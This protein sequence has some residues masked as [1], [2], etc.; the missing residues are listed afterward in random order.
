MREL[1]NE[2][3]LEAGS[4]YSHIKSKEE[5]LHRVCFGLAE[6]FFAGFA[7]A[8]ADAATPV[9]AQLRQAIEAHVQ[10]LTR[11]SAASAVFLHEW[12]HL[13]EPARTE[14]L[15]L[16]DRYEASFRALIERGIAAGELEA[17]DAAFAALTL[18]ASLNW[19]PSWYRPD[20]K[21]TPAEIAHR[22]AEQLLGG[23]LLNE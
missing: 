20:G 15:A 3:G 19:L 21:L 13:T 18:L 11:D 2:L 6:E 5:I 1:A 16:R 14:F 23:L 22:L 9:A 10:V 12:R 4:L 7:G 8:T 17:P